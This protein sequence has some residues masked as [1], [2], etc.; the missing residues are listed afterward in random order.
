MLIIITIKEAKLLEGK[1]EAQNWKVG[2]ILF[3]NIV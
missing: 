2:C 1:L 3:R